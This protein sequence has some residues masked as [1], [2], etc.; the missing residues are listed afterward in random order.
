MARASDPRLASAYKRVEGRFDRYWKPGDPAK[1]HFYPA[2]GGL[3]STTGDYARF[4]AAWMDG[5]RTRDTRL[6]HGHTVATA[7]RSVPQTRVPQERGN[8]GMQWWLYSDPAEGDGIQLVFGSDGSDGTWA[9]AAPG[10][11]LMVLYFS[12]SRGGSTVFDVMGMVRDLV[13]GA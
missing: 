4:L 6:L 8:H 10:L 11:D 7:L 12:Q 1:L 5:G 2:A 13:Q 3:V 9:M